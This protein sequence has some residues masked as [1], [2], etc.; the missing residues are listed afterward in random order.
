MGPLAGLHTDPKQISELV[1]GLMDS[2]GTRYLPLSEDKI[3]AD[4]KNCLSMMKPMMANMNQYYK[5]SLVKY[6]G[7]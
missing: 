2:Q 6:M 3:D 1:F 5:K 7:M 4:T